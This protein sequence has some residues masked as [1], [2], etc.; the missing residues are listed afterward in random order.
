MGYGSVCLEVNR[1]FHEERVGVTCAETHL[2][3]RSSTSTSAEQCCNAAYNGQITLLRHF[4]H[5]HGVVDDGPVVPDEGRCHHWRSIFFETIR[6]GTM[7]VLRIITVAKTVSSQRLRTKFVLYCP[8]WVF[9]LK[10]LSHQDWNQHFRISSRQ[11][12]A[13]SKVGMC[14]VSHTRS[15]AQTTSNLSS[16]SKVTVVGF[17]AR[18]SERTLASALL[19]PSPGQQSGS[20]VTGQGK[21]HSQITL[22]RSVMVLKSQDDW[23]LPLSIVRELWLNP[24]QRCRRLPSW[25]LWRS[26]CRP[27]SARARASARRS[28]EL[29]SQRQKSYLPSAAPVSQPWIRDLCVLHLLPPRWRKRSPPTSFSFRP[30][31]VA[32][33]LRPRSIDL[34]TDGLTGEGC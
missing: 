22:T 10:N 13:R 2:Q 3:H 12:L 4:T 20:H 5:L 6:T 23:R 31:H 26:C 16:L 15:L 11:S 29:S 30:I 14:S 27:S 17:P 25:A 24:P 32:A 34:S 33:D 19:V 7:H 21:R 18:V 9:N 28:S 8:T 1:V